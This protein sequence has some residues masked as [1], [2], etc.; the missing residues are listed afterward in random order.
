[1]AR[2]VGVG[3]QR[4]V[5]V[6]LGAVPAGEA[7]HDGERA[8][9]D[10]GRIALRVEADEIGLGQHRIALVLAARR[11]AVG[12][13]VLDRGS[14]V[15]RRE[16]LAGDQRS[17]QTEHH[18]ASELAHQR[19]VGREALVAA[20]P[21]IVLRGRE[22]GGEGP[23]DA[24]GGDLGRRR[25]AD[26]ADQRGI[27]GRAEADVVRK[28]GRAGDVVVAVDAVHAEDDRDRHAARARPERGVAIR[29]DQRRP[30]RGRGA[31]V[32]VGAGIAAREDRAERVALEVGGRHRADVALD[33]LADLLLDGHAREQ[34]GDARLGRGVG[35]RGGAVRARPGVGMGDR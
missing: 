23:F 2:R 3:Q 6:V 32:A 34:R 13:E 7:D 30:L 5:A 9:V 31:L 18:R 29:L 33:H 28:D 24:G 4:L 1:M 22:R 15:R 12:E 16:R 14:D 21:A 25:L 11:A 8:G 17:L 19:R 35:D 10:R 26:A 27:A 20:A